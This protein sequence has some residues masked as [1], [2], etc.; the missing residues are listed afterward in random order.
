MVVRHRFGSRG[1]DSDGRGGREHYKYGPAPAAPPPKARAEPAKNRATTAVWIALP[2]KGRLVEW[3]RNRPRSAVPVII[4]AAGG[5][6]L[7]PKGRGWAADYK[8]GGAPGG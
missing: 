4:R 7:L 8:H 2:E 3:F 6:P 1:A 5:S